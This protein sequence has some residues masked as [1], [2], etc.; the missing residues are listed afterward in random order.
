MVLASVSPRPLSPCNTSTTSGPPTPTESTL[1]VASNDDNNRPLQ[2][3]NSSI[4]WPG[5]CYMIR[6]SGSASVI[7]LID[8]RVTLKAPGGWGSIYW[9]CVENHGWLG[10]RAPASG[11]FLGHNMEGKLV[12]G[13]NRQAGWENFCVRAKP[14]GGFVL[15]LTHWEKLWVVGADEGGEGEKQLMKVSGGV[16][17]GIVWDFVKV[18]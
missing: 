12:C 4:P 7:T 10:F 11:Q 9:E 13:A 18:S 8:G 6:A 16:D 15:F 5:S 14:E 17:E 2:T 3:I 1:S